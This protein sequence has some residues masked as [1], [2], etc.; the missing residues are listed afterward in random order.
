MSRELDAQ[1]AEKVLRL[2][3]VHK[4][5]KGE[6]LQHDGCFA[7]VGER[8]YRD[9]KGFFTKLPYYSA[10]IAEA[11]GVVERMRSDDWRVSLWTDEGRWCAQFT[12]GI[13]VGYAKKDT[14]T[15]AICR[16]ALKA[17]EAEHE[18]D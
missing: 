14:V 7:F 8:V 9:D 11:W 18:Q 16:A 5:G 2:Y 10:D 1:V 6:W 3:D 13:Q 4:A 17:R 15:E 12:R